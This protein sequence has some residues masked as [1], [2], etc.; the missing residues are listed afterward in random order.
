MSKS[1]CQ[2]VGQHFICGTVLKFDRSNTHLIPDEMVLD[3]DVLGS[4]VE[5]RIFC[6]SNGRLVVFQDSGGTIWWISQF[7]E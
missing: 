3:V 4:P 2:D 1:L 5:L 7:R 6:H